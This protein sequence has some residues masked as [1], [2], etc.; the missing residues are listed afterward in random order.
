MRKTLLRRNRTA[1]DSE[2]KDEDLFVSQ[3]SSKPNV[4]GSKMAA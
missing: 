3:H 4:T 2:Q 1:T